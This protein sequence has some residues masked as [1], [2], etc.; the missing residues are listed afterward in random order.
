ML[1]FY[2]FFFYFKTGDLV[3][4]KNSNLLGEIVGV[5]PLKLGYM[6]YWQNE[7][8]TDEI[9][10]NLEKVDKIKEGTFG[11]INRENETP[12]YIPP[13]LPENVNFSKTLFDELLKEDID[14]ADDI[15]EQI[16]PVTK[17]RICLPNLRCGAW[18]DCQVNYNFEAVIDMNE[19]AGQQYKSC[20]DIN[21]CIPDIV[22]S[23][24]CVSK[25]NITLGTGFWCGKEYT[26]VMDKNGNIL[27]RL[28]TNDQLNYLDVNINLGE[29]YCSYCYDTRKNYDET[30]VDC[31][32]SCKP[33]S[34]S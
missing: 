22:G 23:R 18:G 12:R 25:I 9:V 28:D 3:Y 14:N 8:Y 31:G 6:V 27:A 26:E 13:T 11:Q 7:T 32:G 34:R 29:D 16:P 21:K 15:Y 33:C 30:D 20:V 10:F 2:Y 1:A 24:V 4:K 19:L 5:S 17:R